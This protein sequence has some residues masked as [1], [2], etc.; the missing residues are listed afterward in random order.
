[1]TAIFLFTKKGPDP[2]PRKLTRNRIY[3]TCGLIMLVCMLAMVIYKNFIQGE[4]SRSTFVF[5]AET[6][7][8]IA[9]GASWLTKGGAIYSDRKNSQVAK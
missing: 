9:F 3:I 4:H 8:L 5:W 6:V 2:T 1:M 7:A